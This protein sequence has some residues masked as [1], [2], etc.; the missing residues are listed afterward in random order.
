MAADAAHERHCD[1]HEHRDRCRERE[2][3]MRARPSERALAHRAKRTA[4]VHASVRWRVAHPSGEHIL[5][6]LGESF[7][8]AR[9]LTRSA[10]ALLAGRP[11]SRVL[12]CSTVVRRAQPCLIPRFPYAHDRRWRRVEARPLGAGAVAALSRAA[13]VRA[14]DGGRGIRQSSGT[15]VDRRARSIFALSARLAR[16]AA[17]RWARRRD[18]Q[19]DLPVAHLLGTGLWLLRDDCPVQC[20]I[21]SQR[22]LERRPHPGTTDALRGVRRGLADVV[23][24]R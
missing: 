6:V 2:N 9:L 12:R 3:R 5:E 17:E 15:N 13:R 1:P 8:L 14:A 18:E 23:A 19:G 4:W 16:L 7:L 10:R 20:G 22:A 24:N 11:P 21:A